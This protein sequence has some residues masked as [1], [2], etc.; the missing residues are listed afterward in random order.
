MKKILATL[1]AA[2]MM[3]GLFGVASATA[4]PGPN[5][6]NNKGLCTAYFNGQKNGHNK[7]GKDAPPP[8][9][10]LEERADEADGDEDADSGSGSLET[11]GDVF[12]YCQEF[13]IGGNPTNGRFA[14]TT[15]DAGTPADPSDDTYSCEPGDGPGADGKG[16]GK[17]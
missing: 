7:D 14:C 13:G 11:A 3:M 6:S 8:F 1:G 17:P 2:L 16:K 4:E 12:G 9:L 15:D 5:G 10:A